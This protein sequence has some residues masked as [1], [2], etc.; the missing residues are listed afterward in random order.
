MSGLTTIDLVV[1]GAYFALIAV[2]VARV[3]R[4]KPSAED[5]FLAGRN[6]GWVV[7]GDAKSEQVVDLAHVAD[8]VL[9]R[10]R[11]HRVGALERDQPVGPGS[12]VPPL[13]CLLLLRRFRER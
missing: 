10:G 9:S 5:Y 2:V 4:R 7:I 13:R 11:L 8:G 6:V 12:R 3:A 1:I